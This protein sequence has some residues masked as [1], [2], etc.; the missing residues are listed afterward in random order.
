MTDTD[1]SRASKMPS[2]LSLKILNHD[3]RKHD[4]F[5]IDVVKYSVVGEVESVSYVGRD[6]G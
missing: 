5:G 3:T 4:H 2:R 6:P 1:S